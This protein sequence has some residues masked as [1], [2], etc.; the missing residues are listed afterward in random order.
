MISTL[1][2]RAPHVNITIV[3]CKVQGE[4]SAESLVN[5]LEKL[6]QCHE[7][8]AYDAANNM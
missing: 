6:E 4:G 3:P 7:N 8:Q 5:A 1:Q 2:R